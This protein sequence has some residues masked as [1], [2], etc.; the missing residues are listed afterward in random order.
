MKLKR[1]LPLIVFMI[2]SLGVQ[3]ASAD[4]FLAG[5]EFQSRDTGGYLTFTDTFNASTVTWSSNIIIFTDF[6]NENGE[7]GTLGFDLPA[8]INVSVTEVATGAISQTVTYT[9]LSDYR[10]YTPEHG[11]PSTITGAADGWSW[12]AGQSTIIISIENDATIG[13]SW[14]TWYSENDTYAAPTWNLPNLINQYLAIGDI[15]GFII[16]PYTMTMGI[17]FFPLVFLMFIIPSQQRIGVMMTGVIVILAW[18]T[19]E[20]AL[21]PEA[22]N[23]VNIIMRI[24]LAGALVYLFFARR[25]SVG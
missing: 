13:M 10:V 20:I 6:E 14:S 15:S 12:T 24:A 1:A 23:L 5:V 9:A 4:M 21:F 16:S 17:M 7:F 3:A 22:I 2:V 25:R 8:G 19:F 11:I 18:T